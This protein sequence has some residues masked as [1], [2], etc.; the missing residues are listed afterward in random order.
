MKLLIS[1]VIRVYKKSRFKISFI[2]TMD[3]IETLIL[4]IN[5][6]IVGNFIDEILKGKYFYLKTL[7]TLEI[8]YGILHTMNICLDT[9]VY[10]KIIE[11]EHDSY[12]REF[13]ST[14][15]NG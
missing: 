1:E 13:C 10:S 3:L 2:W 9:H 15:V 5:P 12:Y 11:E 14:E 7:I 4:A 8:I 6:Y